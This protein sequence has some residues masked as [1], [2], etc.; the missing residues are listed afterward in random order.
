MT[1]VIKECVIFVNTQIGK[2][3]LLLL[4]PWSQTS[5]VGCKPISIK[6]LRHSSSRLLKSDPV[7]P[8]QEIKNNLMVVLVS[9]VQQGPRTITTNACFATPSEIQNDLTSPHPVTQ[10]LYMY[11]VSHHWTMPSFKLISKQHYN[12]TGHVQTLF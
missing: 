11:L 7:T 6:S 1:L 9:I 3:A 5:V 12:Y 8:S 4:G 10:L 2:R